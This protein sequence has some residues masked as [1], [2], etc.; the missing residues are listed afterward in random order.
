MPGRRWSFPA[1][2]FGKR[3][4]FSKTPAKRAI[5]MLRFCKQKRPL[6]SRQKGAPGSPASDSLCAAGYSFDL[7]RPT[8]RGTFPYQGKAFDRTKH[9]WFLPEVPSW[10]GSCRRR[11]RMRETLLGGANHSVFDK[12]NPPSLEAK[13]GLR[14]L[15]I[16]SSC[17]QL[18]KRS[19][20]RA[21]PGLRPSRSARTSRSRWSRPAGR[22]PSR[23]TCQRSGRG[24]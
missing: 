19:R 5:S 9:R 14:F 17:W 23:R 3:F 11:R 20:R 22:Q 7:I 4:S 21:S 12:I 2:F 13:G 8:Q 6:C 18:R 24:P 10:G 15:Q 1:H 16:I